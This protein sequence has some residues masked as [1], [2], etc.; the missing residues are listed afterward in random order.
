MCLSLTCISCCW[1]GGDRFAECRSACDRIAGMVSFI[2]VAVV[3]AFGGRERENVGTAV[4]T[5]P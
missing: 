2:S 3:L 5:E 1:P 4:A